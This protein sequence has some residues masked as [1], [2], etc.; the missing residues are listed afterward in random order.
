L[1]HGNYGSLFCPICVQPTASHH[2]L[3][4][5]LILSPYV[6]LCLGRAVAQTV[7]RWFPTA[8]T[9]VRVQAKSFGICDGR[10]STE[11]GFLR[12]LEFLLSILVPPNTPYSSSS[13]AGTIGQLVANIQSGLSLTLHHDRKTASKSPNWSV[14]FRFS[15]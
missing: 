11:E 1:H 2:I 7:S 4:L 13:G 9:R 3:S 8:A 10:N 6:Y 5:V 15:A 14:T 12:V